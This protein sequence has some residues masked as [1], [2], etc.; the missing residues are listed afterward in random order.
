MDSITRF[1]KKLALLVRREKFDSELQEEMRFHREEKEKEL[2][3]EGM[4]PEAAH[5]AAM[6]QFGNGTRLIEQSHEVVGFR[7]ETVWQDFRFSIRQLRRSPGFTATA[8]MMLALGIGASVAIFAFVD[9]ALIQPLP[10]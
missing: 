4:A 3:D 10:Y 1:F 5:R 7:L 8:T 6:R 9:A 2:R